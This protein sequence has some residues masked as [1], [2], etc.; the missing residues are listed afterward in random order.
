MNLTN[1]IVCKINRLG[2]F[3][4][5]ISIS[6]SKSLRKMTIFAH[7]AKNFP[8]LTFMLIL[9]HPTVGEPLSGLPNEDGHT[10]VPKHFGAQAQ[11]A[12]PTY[13]KLLLQ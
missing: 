10:C 4:L 1:K 11:R 6:V 5:P 9:F 3:F 8:L 7:W 12:V 13:L 2:R